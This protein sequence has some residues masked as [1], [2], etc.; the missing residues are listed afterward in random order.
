M[1]DLAR[2]IGKN[3][4]AARKAAGMTQ[5]DVAE[6][7]GLAT[8]VY[9]RIERGGMLPSVPTL[10]RVAKVLRVTANDLVG[11]QRMTP[12][13]KKS[14]APELRRL[15]RLLERSDRRALRRILLVVRAMS[16]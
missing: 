9:G 16:K 11:T 15:V 10:V 8:E 12:A 13:S 7:V 5:A 3:A 4:R 6:E 1:D 2:R 14:P